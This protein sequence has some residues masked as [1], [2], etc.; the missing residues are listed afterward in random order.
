MKKYLMIAGLTLTAMLAGCGGD[1]EIVIGGKPWTEQ[2]I[3]PQIIGQYIEA[4]SEYK[5][6]YKEGLGA[7]GILTPALQ[8]GEIDLYVEYTGTGL[9]DV[10]KIPD[11]QGLTSDEAYNLVKEGYAND[12]NVTWMPRLG[13]ENA[14]TLATAKDYGVATY[15]E[16]AKV[17]QAEDFLFGAPHTFYERA[18]DGYDSLVEKYSFVFKEHK[19]IDANVMYEALKNGDVDMI[20]AFTTDSR[21]EAFNL[22]V[23]EDDQNFFPKYDAAPI[24]NNDSLE[25]FPEL[26]G[27]LA[28]LGGQI[29]NDEMLAMNA[30]VDGGE[31]P[32][33][34][35]L[36]FLQSKGLVE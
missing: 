8:N 2:Y 20:P 24:V 12:L 11:I 10:L 14:Y 22:S 16:L 21:I 30:L 4:N 25:E 9:M 1:E 33:D 23:Y 5:V 35:A 17:T 34:V 27:L 26:E 29:T 7:T 3:L 6:S 13:F 19:N 28:D 15:S 36:D 31:K 18:N 32:E